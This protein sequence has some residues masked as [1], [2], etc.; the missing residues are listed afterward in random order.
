MV[1]GKRVKCAFSAVF[2]QT[3]ERELYV[4][5]QYLERLGGEKI[6]RVTVWRWL[7]FFSPLPDFS[8][9]SSSV[10]LK[11]S[12]RALRKLQREQEQQ[13]QLAALNAKGEDEDIEGLEESVPSAA[14]MNAK[15]KKKIKLN[16]FQMLEQAD[17]DEDVTRRSAS[18]NEGVRPEDDMPGASTPQ[19]TQSKK[20]KKRRPKDK[21]IER[22]IPIR[23]KIEAE[24]PKKHLDGVDEIDRALQELDMRKNVAAAQQD[25]NEALQAHNSKNSWEKVVSKLL[26]VDSKNLNPTN[27][28][29]SLFGSIALERATRNQGGPDNEGRV[30]LET[31]LNGQH[32]PASRGKELGNL[33]KRRNIFMQG[34]ENWPLATSGG[35]GMEATKGPEGAD[36]GPGSTSTFEKHYEIVHSSAYRDTQRRFRLA[37][38]SMSAENMIHLLVYNPYHAATL[39]Q[40]AEIAKHQGDHS[41]TG[42]LLERVLFSFGRSVHSTFGVSLRE[43]RARL[44]FGKSTNRE[45]YLAIWRYIQN[46]E[47]R[48]TWRTAFEWSKMLLS[49]NILSDPYGIT[50]AL[51]Q[52]ALRGRQHDAFIELCSESAFGNTWSHLPNMQISLAIAYHRASRPK[53]ARQKLALAMHRYPYIF[54]HLCSSLEISPPPKSLWGISPSTDAE[55]LYTEL[56]VT[57]AK[58]LWATP[59]TTALLVEVAETLDSYSHLWK[60]ASAAPKLE[61]SLEDARH[62]L[63]LDIPSLIAL[64]PRNFRTLPTAQYDVLPPPSSANDAGLTARA[65]G[66]VDWP[67]QR[68]PM[69]LLAELVRAA[70]RGFL[71]GGTTAT[72]AAPDNNGRVEHMNEDHEMNNH[73]LFNTTLADANLSEADRTTILAVLAADEDG[74][75]DSDSGAETRALP[76]P[77]AVAINS[78]EN[79]IGDHHDEARPFS[80]EDNHSITAPDAG[81]QAVG[82]DAPLPAVQHGPPRLRPTSRPPPPDTAPRARVVAS[83]PPAPTVEDA[84]ESANSPQPPPPS[85]SSP[86]TTTDPQNSI[87]SSSS[88]NNNSITTD[89][90]DPQRI[91]RFLLSAGLSDLEAN[92]P[93]AM[94]EYVRRLRRLRQRD[95]EWI[96]NVLGQRLGKSRGEAEAEAEG[97]RQGC[98]ER[99]RQRQ[100]DSGAGDESLVD[101]IRA[102]VVAAEAEASPG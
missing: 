22:E 91:Q 74:D 49:F 88:N 5:Y 95:R 66:A 47:M 24:Q 79:I 56:Y 20:K 67:G 63:L 102:A 9:W 44:S 17:D 69:G 41:V 21:D 70:S 81:A 30:D 85:S 97:Q 58:D 51:D 10:S 27:E 13:E 96:F 31:A 33:A 73:D 72:A 98:Q 78:E 8:I 7:Q 53:L 86:S 64:I 93:G 71:G 14:T 76:Q 54:S 37:V 61:V 57:R 39:L 48:G 60:N 62:I 35:L 28:M 4:I 75:E 38:E 11:M 34:Q 40:V 43:G 16:A 46:L 99:D 84:P 45:L 65:P 32:S 100:R 55:K 6:S 83:A 12:T 82:I 23:G 50:H 92:K 52:Y 25:E 68:G 42:D 101:R 59:E 3:F 77:R 26:M 2:P 89:Q 29:R 1:G 94:E 80:S 90:P 18:D 36:S 87:N 19:S 15:R